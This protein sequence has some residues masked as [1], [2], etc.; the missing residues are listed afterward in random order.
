MPSKAR[1]WGG[2]YRYNDWIVWKRPGEGL[3]ADI[4]SPVWGDVSMKSMCS[5]SDVSR[6]IKA[7]F[8]SRMW[9]R[10]VSVESLRNASSLAYLLRWNL[11]KSLVKRNH[12]L[13]HL[14]W[15]EQAGGLPYQR[16][17]HIRDIQIEPAWWTGGDN[18]S[19]EKSSHFLV[20][21]A[22]VKQCGARDIT[23]PRY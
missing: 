20:V 22:E 11:P 15:S 18:Q 23:L 1:M 3:G 5:P 10:K 19:R 7:A 13:Y 16:W 21:T 14:L 8:C 9:R 4:M 6:R 2:F 12:L 17:P